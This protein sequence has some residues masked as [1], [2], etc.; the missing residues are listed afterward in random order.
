[1]NCSGLAAVPSS[2]GVSGW[3]PAPAAAARAAGAAVGGAAV[4]D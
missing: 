1:M 3:N 4:V 2:P